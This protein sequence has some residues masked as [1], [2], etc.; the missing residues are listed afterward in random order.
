MPY[1]AFETIDS[2]QSSSIQPGAINSSVDLCRH[3][4]FWF[5]I[6]FR[7]DCPMKRQCIESRYPEDEDND[8]SLRHRTWATNSVL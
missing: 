6:L 1:F 5:N 2:T 8:A 3:M 7:D 4:T